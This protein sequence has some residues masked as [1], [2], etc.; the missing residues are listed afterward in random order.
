MRAWPVIDSV[1]PNRPSGATQRL[2]NVSEKFQAILG[3]ILGTDWTTPRLV[4]LLITPDGHLLGR[5]DDQ[6]PR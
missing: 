1:Q 4:E 3:C 5:C 6:V 2:A